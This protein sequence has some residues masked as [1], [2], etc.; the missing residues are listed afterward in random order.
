MRLTAMQCP[1]AA[2]MVGVSVS[3]VSSWRWQRSTPHLF[4]ES[5]VATSLR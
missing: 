3:M 4:V 1:R 5:L 2:V